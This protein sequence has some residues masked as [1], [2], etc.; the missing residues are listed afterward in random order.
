MSIELSDLVMSVFLIF[1]RIGT[2]LLMM[3]GF[4]SSRIPMQIRL[5]V[6]VAISLALSPALLP[7]LQPLVAGA[8]GSSASKRQGSTRS[9]ARTTR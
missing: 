1:C 4:S 9:G 5:F 3:P 7:I 6:S 8:G 2:C